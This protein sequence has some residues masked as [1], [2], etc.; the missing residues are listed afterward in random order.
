MRYLASIFDV[1]DQ[2]DCLLCDING[3]IADGTFLLPKVESSLYKLQDK[4]KHIIFVSNATRTKEMVKTQLIMTGLDYDFLDKIVTSGDVLRHFMNNRIGE[5][6]NMKDSAKCFVFGN[7]NFLIGMSDISLVDDI[8]EADYI[9]LN[10]IVSDIKV[11]DQSCFKSLVERGVPF[12]CTNPDKVAL[13]GDM[14]QGQGYA[15]AKYK[16]MGGQ[17]YSYGKPSR[18]IYD[19]VFELYPGLKSLKCICVGDTLL[20]DIKGAIGYGLDSIFITHGIHKKLRKNHSSISSFFAD[21]GIVPTY[22]T[23]HF[24]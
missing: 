14:F 19:R 6:S 5:F 2:Y 4:G 3:V 24:A 11:V 18:M 9:I 7:T 17:V 20:T 10:G 1:I 12:I 8:N 22:Y 16:Q 13:N 23:E 15:A 21:H